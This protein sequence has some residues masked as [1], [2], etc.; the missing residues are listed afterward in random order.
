MYICPKCDSTHINQERRLEG[1]M[2][3]MDCDFRIERK[4]KPGNPF[5]PEQISTMKTPTTEKVALDKVLDD[6]TNDMRARLHEMAN[7]GKT[8]W[9][10][11]GLEKEMAE[12]LYMDVGGAYYCGDRTKLHDIA[13]HA[14]MLWWQAWRMK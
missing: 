7:K 1:P 13:N 11:P 12:H 9:D 3:C 8:G 10:D 14:M 6:F 4:E 5:V 2:W